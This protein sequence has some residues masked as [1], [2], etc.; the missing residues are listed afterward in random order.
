M[1]AAADDVARVQTVQVSTEA[2]GGVH[3]LVALSSPS[4]SKAFFL[5]SPERLVVDFAGATLTVRPSVAPGGLVRQVRT[6]QREDGSTRVV[7]DLTGPARLLSPPSAAPAQRHE[8]RLAPTGTQSTASN[9]P[10]AARAEWVNLPKQ[11]P[12]PTDRRRVIV[13][14]AGHGGRDPG[15]TGAVTGVREKEVVLATAMKLRDALEARGGY[16]VVLTREGDVFLPL[17]ERVKIA[18]ENEADLFVSLHADAHANRQARGASVYTLSEQGSARARTMMEAQDWHLDIGDS[19]SPAVENILVDLAQRETTNRSADFAQ[20]LI[21][22][23]AEAGPLL[24]NTHRNAGF[25]VLLAPDVPAV[26]VELGFLTHPEDEAR[27]N[28][29]KQRKVL[30]SALADAVD[31]YFGRKGPALAERR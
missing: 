1:G 16:Q 8:F 31:I 10:P 6:A 19:R 5:H 20:T 25:F 28:D 15:A 11:A 12:P 22:E 24:R 30:V 7:L 14:D 4:K 2:D 21:G 17:Q 18:R 3:L 9:Q 29:P 23:L 27:L 26:L 13:I